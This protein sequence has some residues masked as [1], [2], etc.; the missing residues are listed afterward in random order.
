MKN[1]ILVFISAT[2]LLINGLFGQVIDPPTKIITIAHR[3]GITPGIPENTFAAF[4]S[5]IKAGVDVIEVDL[6]ATKDGQIVI[7][8]DE[9][10]DRTTNGQGQ[11]TDFTLNA[12]KKLDAG[13]GQE[14]PTFSEL[15]GL[16]SGSGLQLLLDIKISQNLDKKSVIRL[17]EQQ[18]MISDVIVGV[19][20]VNDL[21]E[22]HQLNPNLT[23]LGFIPDIG[24]LDAFF[25]NGVDIIR[26]WPDWIMT[27]PDIAQTIVKRGLPVWTTAGKM[28][29][30][31]ILT[32]IDKGVTGIIHDDPKML[33]SIRRLTKY[34]QEDDKKD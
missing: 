1:L 20:S 34:Q 9:T 24:L 19:R 10:V 23:T 7:L 22:F 28:P 4:Q 27:H 26:L 29:K 12:L 18:S 5:S 25:E 21:I 15:L 33:R 3:G 14:I 32:L 11:V 13:N 8:H 30:D 6:R 17:I 31:A 16:I 2:T